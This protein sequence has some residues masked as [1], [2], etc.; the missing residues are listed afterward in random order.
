MK[1]DELTI[2]LTELM[3]YIG[4]NRFE[5]E[6]INEIYNR[7]SLA[8]LKFKIPYEETLRVTNPSELISNIFDP[9]VQDIQN[10]QA[11]L[12]SKNEL[13]KQIEELKSKNNILENLVND[14]KPFKEHFDLEM[15]LRHGQ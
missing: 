7:N 4:L 15:K 1:S 9:I 13:S 14:L 11:V 10:S 2:I 3:K 5:V 8:L 6:V 12:H